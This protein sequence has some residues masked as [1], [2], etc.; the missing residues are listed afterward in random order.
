MLH[1]ISS[2]VCYL[3]VICLLASAA[4]YSKTYNKYGKHETKQVVGNRT[5]CQPHVQRTRALAKDTGNASTAHVREHI[6]L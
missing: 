5:S 6:I 3:H 1:V 2:H 4:L